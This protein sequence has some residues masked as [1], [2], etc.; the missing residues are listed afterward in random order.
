MIR[1]YFPWMEEKLAAYE[2]QAP[3]HKRLFRFRAA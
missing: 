3:L 2:G 1:T